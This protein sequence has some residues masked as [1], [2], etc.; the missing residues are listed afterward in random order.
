MISRRTVLTGGLASGLALTIIG[1]AEQAFALSSQPFTPVNFKV[2][3]N[4]C[5]CH[6]HIHGDPAKYPFFDGRVYTPEAALPTE[7][8]ALHKRLGIK[9]VV[10][11]TPSVYGPDNASTLYGVK[12]RGKNARGVAVIDNRTARCEL[13]D[14]DDGGIVG[15]RLNLTTGGTNDPKVAGE[16][17]DAAVKRIR[18]RGWH[19]QIYTNLAMISAIK[20][21]VRTSPVP[22]VFDHFGGARANL[23]VEQPGF[24]DLLDLLRTGKVYVKISAAYRSSTE[25]PDYANAAPLA[26]ALIAANPSRIIWGTDWPHPNSTPPA[27]Q[28]LSDVT[29][30]FQIDDG[31]VMNQ[32]AVWAPEAALRRRIL[33][34]NPEELYG[35]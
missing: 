19:V 1:R 4:A 25:G 12:A 2:P 24:S 31:R 33:V 14:M 7:M 22:V 6:T 9:R 28:K 35:F 23:G 3:A 21:Q 29:P 5:D 15:I 18:E 34:D 17:F 32:L 20:D 10:I 16:R 8:A 11:V 30:S 27:G 26:K 13:D